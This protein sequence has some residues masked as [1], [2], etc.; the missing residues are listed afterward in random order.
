MLSGMPVK[1]KVSIMNSQYSL[2]YAFYKSTLI[3]INPFLLLLVLRIVWMTSWATIILSTICLPG[4]KLL[5]LSETKVVIGGL[6][7]LTTTSVT[8]LKMH[9]KGQWVWTAAASLVSTL[10]ELRLK[11]MFN[12]CYILFVVK[13]ISGE[14]AHFATHWFW[15]MA[16]NHPVSGL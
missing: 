2:S 13:N 6:S 4:K 11:R 5:W 16:E 10:L 9:C 14:P 1:I 8:I 15:K 3:T 7:R 12:F